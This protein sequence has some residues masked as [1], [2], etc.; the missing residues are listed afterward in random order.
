MD[1]YGIPLVYVNFCVFMGAYGGLWVW[2]LGT[3]EV[4]TDT[5]KQP[6]IPLATHKYL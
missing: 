2:D 5:H 6:L 3:H 4:P 1:I